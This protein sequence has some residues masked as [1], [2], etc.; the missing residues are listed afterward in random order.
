MRL[1]IKRN[2]WYTVSYV[3]NLRRDK[4][5]DWF[6]RGYEDHPSKDGTKVWSCDLAR[7][8]ARLV[9]RKSLGHQRR[10]GH[11]RRRAHQTREAKEE[12]DR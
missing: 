12:V 8:R 6:F 9:G 10:I 4:Y 11:Q 2:D 1:L 5:T 7:Q 3:S